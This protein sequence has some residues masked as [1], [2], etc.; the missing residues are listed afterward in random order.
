[1]ARLPS[2]IDR[3]TT[4]PKLDSSAS[5][6]GR[7]HRQ[8]SPTRLRAHAPAEASTPL[9]SPAPATARTRGNEQPPDVRAAVVLVS[10]PNVDS[11]PL[12]QAKR[13]SAMYYPKA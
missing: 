8:R 5:P 4:A 11:L 3:A 1:M 2:G 9:D 10:R 7:F 13:W 12:F 6:C